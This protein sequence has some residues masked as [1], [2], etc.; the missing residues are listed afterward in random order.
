MKSINVTLSTTYKNKHID[1]N[2][3]QCDLE[4]KFQ[5]GQHTIET[6]PKEIGK[7]TH[8]KNTPIMARFILSY[9]FNEKNKTLSLYGTGHTSNNSICL[10]TYLKNSNE[11]CFQKITNFSLGEKNE[12]FNSNWNYTTQ[13][14]PNLENTFIEVITLA[15][16]TFIEAVKNIEG[17]TVQIR[18]LPP[19]FSS[20]EHENYSLVYKNDAFIE[21]YNPKKEYGKDYTIKRIESVWGGTVHFNN[22]ENFANVIGSTYDPKIG[23]DSWIGLWRNQFGNPNICT[24][25]QYGGFNCNNNLV[26]GHIIKG[27]QAIFVPPASNSVYIMPICS[28][29][30]NN[31]NVYM[32]ALQYLNGI[33]LNN[34]MH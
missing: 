11:H 32:A 17:L 9:D 31:D 5:N 1:I 27:Q 14:T 6:E 29:H 13:L 20:E 21:F 3:T 7:L 25:Y 19:K 16:N 10:N 8:Y 34:Y 30:N 2:K 23:G 4:L 26:G 24:S 15:N 22:G 28:A 12:L 18:T 33:W